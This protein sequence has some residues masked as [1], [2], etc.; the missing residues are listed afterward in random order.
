MYQYKCSTSIKPLFTKCIF[1][2]LQY[3]SDIQNNMYCIS[4]TMEWNGFK[5]F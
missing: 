5:R 4:A 3:Y 2:V 1:K